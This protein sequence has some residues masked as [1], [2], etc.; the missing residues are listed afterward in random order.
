MDMLILKCIWKYKEPKIAKKTL[1]KIFIYLG[2]SE[3]A[4]EKEHKW[5]EGQRKKQALHWAGS[6]TWDF[7]PTTWAKGNH[8]NWLS[9]PGTPI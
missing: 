6:P 8:L 4:S 9:H 1:F 7:D 3:P 5:G 2:E